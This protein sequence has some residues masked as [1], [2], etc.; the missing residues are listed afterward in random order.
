[1]SPYWWAHFQQRRHFQIRICIDHSHADVEVQIVKDS[2]PIKK[3]LLVDVMNADGLLSGIADVF[4]L[5]YICKVSLLKVPTVF[6][7]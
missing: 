4:I 3:D 7:T 5:I 2:V 1:M 6:V